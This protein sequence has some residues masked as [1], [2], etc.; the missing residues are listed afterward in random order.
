METTTTL[1]K[2]DCC[3][4]EREFLVLITAATEIHNFNYLAVTF[5]VIQPGYRR[6]DKGAVDK[7]SKR[8]PIGFVFTEI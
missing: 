5:H 1:V 7:S 3:N 2:G 6:I 8:N 4:C